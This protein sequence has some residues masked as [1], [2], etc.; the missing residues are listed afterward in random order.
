M[1]PFAALPYYRWHWR[2]YRANRKV[3]SMTYTERGLYRE[4]LDECWAEGFIPDDLDALAE[5]CGCPRDVLEGCWPKLRA[6]FVEAS[7]GALINPR[8]D[9]ERTEKD[10][11]RAS[12]A[13]AGALGGSVR[14]RAEA[15]HVLPIAEQVLST[16]HI[17]VAGARAVAV[18]EQA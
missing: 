2:D 10:A 15:K 4:L 18:A 16:C 14:A 3:Q 7:P 5:I 9:K 17:A 13:V 11:E 12:K 8:M 1:S 6:C